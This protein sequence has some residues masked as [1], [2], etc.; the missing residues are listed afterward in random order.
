MHN[1]EKW[2]EEAI[3]SVINQTYRDLQILVID[4]GSEDKSVERVLSFNDS[5]TEVYEKNH[6]G[7]ASSLNYAI[8]KIKGDFVARLGSDDFCN[9]ERIFK[10][11][12][13]LNE[14][15]SY[16][17][18]GSNFILLDEFG[19]Q[20]DKIRN[21]EKHEDIIE[22]LPR[23][24]C[25]WDGSALMRTGIIK[26]LNG[27]DERL[28]SGDDW[29]FF[30]RAIDLTK[31]YNIQE[32]LT[33]KRFHSDSASSSEQAA[34]D[35]EDILL[36]YNKSVIERSDDQKKISKAYFN[37]GYHYYY[38]SEF[39]TAAGNFK[40]ALIKDNFNFQYIRYFIFSKYLKSFV[41]ISRKYRLY[42]LLNWLRYLDKGDK[43]LS[44]KF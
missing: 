32:Y 25:V 38:K 4:D 20:I 14:N 35:T 7:I 18:V 19:K 27:F 31:F 8:S 10:Q 34:K 33:S 37:I 41:R 39:E 40:T 30:L 1:S 43:Y 24:C 3:R 21:P 22:Q 13:F 9:K 42:K 28:K 36:S 29:D 17:I 44:S 12:E 2:I 6:S 23:R 26:E 5:R 16:G 15:E 11:V